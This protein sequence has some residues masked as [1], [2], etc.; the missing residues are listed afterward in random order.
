MEH[1]NLV[2]Y[3]PCQKNLDDKTAAPPPLISL[4]LKSKHKTVW[5]LQIL[6]IRES[7]YGPLY[8]LE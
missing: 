5:I 2:L 4:L 7:I 3:H 6:V 8:V 1:R